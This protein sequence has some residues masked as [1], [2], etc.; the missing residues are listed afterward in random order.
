MDPGADT[1]P[2]QYLREVFPT[3]LEHQK[4]SQEKNLWIADDSRLFSCKN[5][6][7]QISH[8]HF[9]TISLGYVFVLLFFFWCLKQ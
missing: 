4:N 1:L 8:H 9:P 6:M 7:K 5:H 3:S 2:R